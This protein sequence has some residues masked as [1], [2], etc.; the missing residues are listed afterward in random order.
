MNVKITKPIQGGTIRAI[1]SKSDAHRLLICAALADGETFID[2]PERSE[3]IDATARCLEALGAAIRYERNG[4]FVMPIRRDMIMQSSDQHILDCGE[5][6]STLR[7]IMPIC[8]ALGIMSFF[9]MS[10][11]LPERPMSGL[12]DEMTTHGC[13]LSNPG[14]SPM[15]CEGKLT[16]GSYTLPGNISSQF[17]SGLL[18]ALP[19]LPGDSELR[20]MGVIE[21][22][23]YV[24]MTLDT[25]RLFGVKIFEDENN[26]LRIPGNQSFRSPKSVNV[27]GDWSNA[28]FW[29]AAG[30]MGQ[31]SVSCTNL[32]LKSKQGDRAVTKMLSRFGAFVTYG[33]GSVTVS[34][35]ALRGIEIDAGDTP[36]LVP[37]LA[38]V[39]SVA[40]GKTIIRN[41]GRLRIK[42]SDRLRTVAATL[43]G[44]GA[45]VT[46]TDDGL[47][48]NGKKEL[49]GGETES[50]G[51]HRI[52]MTAAAI[53]I[54][55]REPVIIKGSEAVNKSY[56]GFWSD[57]KTSLNGEWEEY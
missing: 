45:D 33:D 44:L 12:Y 30:A 50:F 46:E 18:F 48:I 20:V 43:S 10:G 14:N 7:F 2:C 5:S 9:N 25:L 3:D 26:T 6:G 24:D 38:A 55:C 32:S 57:F 56:P 13:T 21:S 39:A 15:I 29:L 27:E 40:E 41:A 19:L 42:E 28:A 37:I 51:D 31:N 11:R 22:R 34:P 47:C 36:D 52:A 35:G 17:I 8:G 4:F 54:V 1:A 53:S 16:S 49:S 23:P